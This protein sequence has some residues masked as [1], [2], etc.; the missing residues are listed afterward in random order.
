MYTFIYFLLLYTLYTMDSL[1]DDLLYDILKCLSCERDII[2]VHSISRKFSNLLKAS[3]LWAYYYDNKYSA[4]D[5][6]NDMFYKSRYVIYYKIESLIRK[7]NI[8]ESIN[9]TLKF[10]IL[11]LMSK[12]I[13]IIPPEIGYLANL[14]RLYL[15]DNQIASIP[16]E[17]GQLINLQGLYLG[18][19]QISSIPSEIGQLANLQEL[20]LGYNQITSIPSEIGQLANL[21]ILN[22]G[23][24]QITSIPSEIGQLVNLLQL[25]LKN[26]QIMELPSLSCHLQ[27]V[28]NI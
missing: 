27:N 28:I 23:N 21:Q 2:N 17:I 16:S 10:S 11:N 14:Q 4:C 5:L 19:N 6:L 15:Y 9:T 20:Y 7:L 1:C 3:H 8:K 25:D 13:K 22:L 18:K 12:S 24:N 26:N